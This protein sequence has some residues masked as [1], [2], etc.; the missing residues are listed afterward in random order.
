MIIPLLL[1]FLSLAILAMLPARCVCGR[2]TRGGFFFP[3]CT[4]CGC[5][6][7]TDDYSDGATLAAEY[8]V[9]SGSWTIEAGGFLQTASSNAILIC[10]TAVPAGATRLFIDVRVTISANN[11]K[12]RIFF[13]YVDVNNCWYAQFG[14]TAAGGVA[15]IY[16][17][18]AGTDTLRATFTDDGLGDHD[19]TEEATVQLSYNDLFGEIRLDVYKSGA[20]GF[21]YGQSYLT[22]I[23]IAGTYCGLGADAATVK[24]DNL[25]IDHCDP[26]CY[27]VN[28]E[29][30]D[31]AWPATITCTITNADCANWDQTVTMTRTGSSSNIVYIKNSPTDICIGTGL[32]LQLAC[33]VLGWRILHNP[34]LPGFSNGSF[35]FPEMIIPTVLSCDPFHATVTASIPLGVSAN[36]G[37]F[38]DTM[39]IEFTE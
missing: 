7:F 15:D 39:D 35:N 18:V 37:T 38:G 36:C 34:C 1:F 4:C 8:T 26:C 24:F 27:D 12:G 3:G 32:Q 6:F 14:P 30:D 2:G 11:G 21:V 23:T 33:D 5:I 28:G 10:D 25:S 22:T 17:R 13:A 9:E 31:S 19:A 29:G 20:S 16:E